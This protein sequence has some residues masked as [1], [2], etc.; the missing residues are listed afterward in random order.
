MGKTELRQR[1][2]FSTMI[3]RIGNRAVRKAQRENHRKGL[4]NIYSKN[5][6]IYY[7]WPDGSLTT[8]GPSFI[9]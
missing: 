1:E 3:T 8:K 7:Q 4:P 5:G 6:Q 2:D 9:K